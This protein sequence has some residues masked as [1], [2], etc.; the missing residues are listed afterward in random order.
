MIVLPVMCGFAIW[1]SRKNYVSG[2]ILAVLSS[3]INLIF[4]ISLYQSES[5][6]LTIPFASHGM[7]IAIHVYEFPA[8]FLTFTAV[9]FLLVS[10]YSAV[11]LKNEN[12]T[13]S[14]ML[15]LFIS[16]AMVNGAILSDNLNIMLFFWEGL[17]CTLFGML[18]I[19]NKQNPKTAAKA[20]VLSGTANLLLMLGIILTVYQAGTPYITQMQKLPVTGISGI[21]FVCMML[22]AIGMAG[23]MPFHSWITNAAEDA[24]VPFMAAFPAMLEKILGIYLAV[25]IV[26]NLYDLQP[27]T[28]MSIALMALGALTVIFADA[29]AFI[30]MDMKRLLS[31]NAISQA[32][33]M[34]LGI[35]T[36]LP[37]GITGG[38][39]H[40]LN[41]VIFSSCMFMAAG[42][43]EKRTGTTD[44][45]KI[46]GLA[47][48]MPVTMACFVISGLATIGIPPFSTFLSKGIIFNA[49]QKS[50]VVFYIAAL[51]STFL[52]TVYFLKMARTVFT[53][54]RKLPSGMKSIRESGFGMLIPMIVLAALSIL[55]GVVNKWPLDGLVGNAL[56]YT[57]TYSGWPLSALSVIIYGIVLIL[58]I[59]DHLYGCW[60]S[61]S[62]VN[63]AD[64]IKNAPV[65]KSIYQAAEK[66]W[67]DPYNWLNQAANA[68]SALCVLI[69]RGISWF[70]DDAVEET[71]NGV[72]NLLQRFNNGSLSRYLLAAAAGVAGVA[73]IF[74]I[75]HS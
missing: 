60:K 25:H 4:A 67:F 71:V 1:L 68:F 26:M 33:F 74:L 72:G 61:G 20:F 44:F 64:H 9:G 30:Q 13:G 23:C 55:L 50:N 12:Y 51:L 17:L 29:M 19:N 70:Y 58:A 37:A 7:D 63:A 3:A 57:Q 49:V 32:G 42:S 16:L 34:V 27:G 31:Y 36:A 10:L 45:R 8:M 65:L 38:L 24:P 14:F 48:S 35:G 21:G 6:Y 56:G 15:Y 66:Q 54:E 52:T 73:V 46:G 75:I 59:C 39:F 47:K 5:F 2:L 41:C 62:A 22:G 40:M 43:I 11:Y 53:G 28:G 18:L 69:E